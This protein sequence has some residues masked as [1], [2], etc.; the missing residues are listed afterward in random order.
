M[1]FRYQPM[2]ATSLPRWA[3]GLWAWSA[4]PG[5]VP[6]VALLAL[7][8]G[9]VVGGGVGCK[10]NEP[11]PQVANLAPFADAGK[12]LSVPGDG[13][14][15]LDGRGSYD[16]DGDKIFFKWTMDTVPPGSELGEGGARGTNPFSPN[17]DETG[18]TTFSPDRVGTYVVQLRVTDGLLDSDR[19]YVIIDVTEP[20]E[21]PQAVAGNDLVVDLGASVVVSGAGSTDPLGGRNGPLQFEWTLSSTPYNSGL[22]TS[23]LNGAATEAVS[24]TPDVGGDFTLS[25]VV[26]NGMSSSIQDSVVITVLTGNGEPIAKAGDDQQFL[27]GA[28]ATLD[29]SASIDP[30]G[31]SLTYFWELQTKPATSALN[32]SSFADRNQAITTLTPDVAGDYQVSVSV[33]DGAVW[34]IPDFLVIRALLRLDVYGSV[35]PGNGRVTADL[36]T[37]GAIDCLLFGSSMGSGTCGADLAE[38]TVVTLTAAPSAGNRFVGWDVQPAPAIDCVDTV[39]TCVVILT[40]NTTV[41]ARFAPLPTFQLKVEGSTLASS[42]GTVTSAPP[43]IDCHVDGSTVGFGTCAFAFPKGTSVTLTAV[44]DPGSTSPSWEVWSPGAPCAPGPTCVITM[45]GNRTVAAGFDRSPTVPLTIDGGVTGSPGMP[46]GTIV[47]AALGINC[48]PYGYRVEGTCTADL[49][50]GTVVTLTALP[51]TGY[52][53][54]SLTFDAGQ[55]ACT[56]SP[57]QVTVTAATTA[58]AS[59]AALPP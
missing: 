52:T 8:V 1:S 41:T 39:T 46:G 45:E 4:R 40:A 53:F 26:S 13:T 18:V 14:V 2:H 48:T 27:L 3:K 54:T 57:C 19:S 12:N 56:S 24:F 23:D 22:T 25:L 9:M 55:P 50:P 34:S 33:F 49:A 37:I 5:V 36:G 32:N 43:G 21:L 29:A 44:P 47:S 30:E 17:N 35:D 38:G 10:Q 28:T 20:N 15:E 51:A 16:P 11:E 6:L 31:S 58:T 7:T 42:P 59:F